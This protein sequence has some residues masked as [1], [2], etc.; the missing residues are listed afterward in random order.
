[1]SVTDDNVIFNTI[2]GNHLYKLTSEDSDKDV[3]YVINS[4]RRK[5]RQSYNEVGWDQVRVGLGTFIT[6]IQEGSHQS[7]EA[8]FSPYKRWNPEFDF[9]E[10]MLEAYRV[11]GPEVFAKYERTITKFCY[12]DFKRRRHAVRLH[13][14]LEDLRRSGMF[15]PVLAPTEIDLCN[16][17]AGNYEGDELR[18]VLL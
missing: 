2:H 14:N 5:A 9:L 17:W 1:M 4:P 3:F 7:V 15:N 13:L 18:E 11:T 10:P 12:G 16:A 8:L 6:R